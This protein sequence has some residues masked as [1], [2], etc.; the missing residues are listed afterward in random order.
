MNKKFGILLT[1]SA[2]LALTLSAANDSIIVT[3]DGRVIKTAKIEVNAKGDLEYLTPDGK[4]KNRI[5]NGRFRYAQVP[6]PA[7]ITEADQNFR[8]Q[9]WKTAAAMYHNAASAWRLLGWEVYCIRMEAES[10]AKS[11][12]KAQAEKLL[13]GLHGTG[14]NNPRQQKERHLADNF[15]AELLIDRKQ[16]DAAEKIL[17]RQLVLDDPELVFS[18]F[19]KKAEIMQGRGLRKEAI[20]LFYQA[21]LLFP[22]NPRRAEALYNT[23]NLMQ[24]IKDPRAAKIAEMLKREYPNSPLAQKVFF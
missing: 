16:F 17:N 11:G 10:L 13:T 22:G 21:A 9:Q 23:W 18:A 2:G 7:E 5:P 3:T 14:E 19:F 12:E 4:L 24:E 20:R 15:L 8:K 6:K 1:A